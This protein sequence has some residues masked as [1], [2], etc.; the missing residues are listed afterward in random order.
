MY[1]VVGIGRLLLCSILPRHGR[2]RYDIV[3]FDL[4]NTEGERHR[5]IADV[6]SLVLE[7]YLLADWSLIVIHC[8]FANFC[9]SVV[10]STF[11]S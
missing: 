5:F 4:S 2:T 6:I 7:I 3:S 11:S 8:Q 10:P 9:L 1:L